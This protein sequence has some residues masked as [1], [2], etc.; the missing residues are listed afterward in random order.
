[1]QITLNVSTKSA[2]DK[3]TVKTLDVK[4]LR[5]RLKGHNTNLDPLK[6]LKLHQLQFIND[7][8]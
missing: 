3:V 1:M 2:T 5:N 7:C 4:R 8:E 6:Y